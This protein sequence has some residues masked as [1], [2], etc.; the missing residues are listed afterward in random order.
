MAVSE[1]ITTLP[2]STQTNTSLKKKKERCSK[3]NNTNHSLPLLSEQMEHQLTNRQKE[4]KGRK[5][6][7][8]QIQTTGNVN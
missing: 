8:H 1:N 2:E 6:L 7:A 5:A 4:K 3:T